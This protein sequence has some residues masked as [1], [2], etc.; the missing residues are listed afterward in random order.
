VT[1]GAEPLAPSLLAA[2]RRWRDRPAVT[3]GGTTTTYAELGRGVARL[4]ASYRRLGIGAGDRVVCQL[5]NSPE[6]VMAVNAAWAV[7]AVHVGTDN[8]LTA[9]ELAWLADRTEAAALLFRAHAGAPDPSALVRAVQAASPGTRLIVA[10]SATGEADH[11]LDDLLAGPDQLED[12]SPPHGPDDTSHLLLTSG[13]TGRPKAVMETLPACWAKMQFFVDAFGP[14]PDDVHLLY[15]PIAHVFGLRLAM[16]AL[17]SGGRLVLMERFSPRGALGLITDEH[18]TVVPGMPAHFTL[19]FDALDPAQHRVDSLRWAISAASTL[20]RPLV[21]QMY[22]RLGVELLYVYGCSENFTVQTTDP[23][24]IRRGSVGRQVFK[25]PE[26]T[27][28]DGS[29]AVVDPGSTQALPPG[30]VGEIAFGA[31]HPVRYWKD[32]DAATDGWYR[33]GDLGRVDPDG[34][35]YILG[36]LKELV[37]RGGL[38]VSPSEVETAVRLHPGVADSA[39]VATPDPVLGEAVCACVVAGPAGAP[40]LAALRDFL[41][42]VL[43]RH[44]LPDELC[45]VDAVPRTKIGKVDRSALQA[46][47]LAGGQPRERWRAE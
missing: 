6:H 18:V 34:T 36:R 43:A 1:S 42:P 14:G 30:T 33:T 38:H 44:K 3:F 17:L 35:V 37:N 19:L 27:P 28:P 12:W 2:C 16:L 31:A 47:V 11:R 13:T 25:G 7:G 41:A 45:L 29:V 20:P 39:V 21:E 32:P 26:G 40:D 9:P 24:E 4:A 15:L 46:S 8:D 10:G 5:P 22:D 23:D